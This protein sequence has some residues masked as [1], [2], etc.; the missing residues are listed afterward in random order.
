MQWETCWPVADLNS[1]SAD[2]RCWTQWVTQTQLG[3]SWNDICSSLCIHICLFG[4]FIYKYTQCDLHRTC[5]WIDIICCS[6]NNIPVTFM[7]PVLCFFP[8]T[9]K[10]TDP[11]SSHT[12][13]YHVFHLHLLDVKHVSLILETWECKNKCQGIIVDLLFECNCLLLP[14]CF[15][16]WLSINI[17]QR[18]QIQKQHVLSCQT[19]SIITNISSSY[20]VE[21][22][23]W[24]WSQ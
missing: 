23:Y 15:S 4:H 22:M 18:L 19:V 1:T 21:W 10:D 3:K 17:C 13:V 24:V 12:C 11:G 7:L 6:W 8:G 20:S 2:C 5:P 16:P 14:S 9:I